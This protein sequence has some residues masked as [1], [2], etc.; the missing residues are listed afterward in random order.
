MTRT[1]TTKREPLVVLFMLL[2]V[3]LLATIAAGA[4][5]HKF[6]EPRFERPQPEFV[7]C[8]NQ[9]NLSIQPTTTATPQ[10]ES[11][12]PL[13]FASSGKKALSSREASA[14]NQT[15]PSSKLSSTQPSTGSNTT[16]PP[17]SPA[18]TTQPRSLTFVGPSSASTTAP[19]SESSEG[20]KEH[21]NPEEP[22]S[23]TL[24]M[25]ERLPRH[26]SDR[27]EPPDQRAERM[28]AHAS[29]IDGVT[30]DR[31]ER[32]ALVVLAG[33]EGVNL[34]RFVDLDEPQCRDG[35]K[36]WCDHSKAWSV[37]QLHGTDRSGGREWAARQALTR[38]RWHGARCAQMGHDRIVGAFAGYA[39]GGKF[40]DTADARDRAAETAR[41][42]GAL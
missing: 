41:R 22:V 3:A 2:V 5:V 21:T 34:A 20:S 40:C 30:R 42:A 9:S 16:K 31:T 6:T 23:K 4:L 25:L 27:D 37:Y 18:K 7:L 26:S 10:E 28:A 32:A 11:R 15:A 19:P 39:T 35:H 12:S 8:S 36:G 14:S 24:V 38:W 13:A 17:S 1:I 33:R 29:A